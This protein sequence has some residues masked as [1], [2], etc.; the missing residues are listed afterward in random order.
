M[1][2]PKIST[3]NNKIFK[4]SKYLLSLK[5]QTL[6]YNTCTPVIESDKYPLGPPPRHPLP[7]DKVSRQT[8]D[9]RD[10][11]EGYDET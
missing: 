3:T 7:R 2:N 9:I 6:K 4:T 8:L 11:Y 5:L 1:R 10:H